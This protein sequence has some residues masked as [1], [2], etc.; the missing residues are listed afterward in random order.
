MTVTLEELLQHEDTCPGPPTPPPPPPAQ[1]ALEIAAGDA[2]TATAAAAAAAAAGRETVELESSRRLGGLAEAEAGAEAGAEEGAGAGAEE[3]AARRPG[4]GEL[5]VLGT[6]GAAPKW[7]ASVLAMVEEGPRD[8]K[9]TD[10]RSL[11]VLVFT[12]ARSNRGA[13]CR[14]E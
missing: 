6:V 4:S 8:G 12:D 11:K 3:P 2:G 10:P 7:S 1:P 9:C 14:L 5:N 13:C